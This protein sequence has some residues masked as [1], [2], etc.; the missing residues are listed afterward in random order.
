MFPYVLAVGALVST[1][2]FATWFGS[3]AGSYEGP[4]AVERSGPE[5]DQ[6]SSL[7]QKLQRHMSE[8]QDAEQRRRSWYG[9]NCTPEECLVRNDCNPLSCLR[10]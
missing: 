4:P 8:A 7:N 5:A 10:P 3:F 1:V 9:R 6:V 2:A